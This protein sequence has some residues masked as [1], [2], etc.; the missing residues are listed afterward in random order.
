MSTHTEICVTWMLPIIPEFGSAH[1]GF[2]AA[3]GNFS[4]IG[5]PTE[6]A[7]KHKAYFSGAHFKK[8]KMKFLHS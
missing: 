6:K 2:L 8:K 7:P 4:I 1:S 3:L 5:K